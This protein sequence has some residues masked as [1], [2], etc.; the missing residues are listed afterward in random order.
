MNYATADGSAT[1]AGADYRAA[2]GTLIFAPG[3]TSKTI[4]VLVNGDRLGEADEYFYV[5]L[6]AATGEPLRDGVGY[7]VIQDDEPRISINSVSVKE[8]NSGTKLMTFTVTLS[9]AYDQAVTVDFATHDD[10]ATVAGGDY[11]AKKGTLTFAPGQT[12]KTFTVTIKGDTKR[13]ADESFYV[14]LSGA[15][16]NAFIPDAYGWGTI[17]NDDPAPRKALTFSPRAPSCGLGDQAATQVRAVRRAT[18]F[19]EGHSP[20]KSWPRP[21]RRRARLP[22]PRRHRPR[23]CRFTTSRP[24]ALRPCSSSSAHRCW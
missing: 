3:Q 16:S 12:T 11:V 10:S 15:S 5:N 24:T 18:N 17:L 7:V 20:C 22:D 19:I 6:T 23:P 14:L 4:T 8:G 9:A 13:E 1:L 21:P 2:S